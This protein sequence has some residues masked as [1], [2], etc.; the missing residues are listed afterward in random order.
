MG[1]FFQ[2][3]KNS[4]VFRNS[5][6]IIVEKIVQMMLSFFLTIV[7]ARYLGTSNYGILNYSTSIITFFACIVKLGFDSI[8]VKELID[9]RDKENIILG[10]TIF[11][12]FISSLI[13]ILLIIALSLLYYDNNIMRLVIIIESFLL[14]FQA[15]SFIEYYFVSYLKSKYVSIAKMVA[16]LVMS[17]YKIIIILL[18]LNVVY[19]AICNIIDYLVLSLILFIFYKKDGN[20]LNI[21][22][23][24]GFSLL[25]KSY[26]FIFSDLIII[27]YT[28]IDKVMIGN[29]MMQSDVG[30]YSAAVVIYMLYEFIPE[31]I[32][33]SFKSKLFDLKN[34]NYKNYI[35]NLKRLFA[36]IFW[37]SVLF[38]LAIILLSKFILNLLYGSSYSSALYPLI[39]LSISLPFANIGI[40][41]RIWMIEQE[42]QKYITII[43]IWG[44]I[45]NIVLN[46]IFINKF[47]I[48]GA[49]I[50]T[51]ITEIF[52]N[53]IVPSFYKKTRPVFK[54]SL[55]GI[56]FKF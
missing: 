6:W 26:H 44:V 28:Q 29:I 1:N 36:L 8:I 49:S 52:V 31:A 12:R 53:V 15:F 9:N 37:M 54:L 45:I 40:V 19:F 33:T 47:G 38:S 41:R 48:V 22:I 21:N 55:D 39:I 4:S 34:K 16:Y 24:Y 20:G 51:L 10:T 50:A 5:T 23:K 11:F 25:K 3:L 27:L 30:I 14:L 46:M 18:K 13:S 35:V 7:I 42:K 17:I 2:N 43:S 56:L 32:V